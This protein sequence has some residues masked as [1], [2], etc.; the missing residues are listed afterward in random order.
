MGPF[1][2]PPSSH[3]AKRDN[4]HCGGYDSV[5]FASRTSSQCWISRDIYSGRI[6]DAD[7]SRPTVLN[8]IDFDGGRRVVQSSLSIHHMILAIAVRFSF[9]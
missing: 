9:S 2:L 4:A 5:S 6:F 3:C 7:F 1:I 8:A